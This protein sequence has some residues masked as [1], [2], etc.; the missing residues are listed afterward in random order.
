MD[1]DGVLSTGTVATVGREGSKTTVPSAPENSKSPNR[2][3]PDLTEASELKFG[4]LL[5]VVSS[6][7]GGLEERRSSVSIPVGGIEAGRNNA[8][9]ICLLPTGTG[10]CP[11]SQPPRCR[12]PRPPDLST[13]LSDSLPMI[14][15]QRRSLPDPSSPFRTPR[16]VGF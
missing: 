14:A 4:R 11:T 3:P 16:K 7:G 5:G 1:L 2:F 12:L 13:L 8:A 10:T 15:T 6:T 9:E